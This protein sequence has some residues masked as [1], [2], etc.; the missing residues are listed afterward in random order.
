MENLFGVVLLQIGISIQ[1][2]SI[3]AKEFFSF[4]ERYFSLLDAL[5]YPYF[6]L[7]N[8][9]LR[10]VL[11]I[12]EHL[13]HGFAVYNLVDMI[14]PVFHGKVHGIGVAKQIVEVAENLLICTNEENT[15]IIRLVATQCVHWKHVAGASSAYEIGYLAIAVAGNVLQ[16]GFPCRAFVQPLYRHDGEKLVD[17][18]TVGKRLEEREVAKIFVC[19]QFV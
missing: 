17:S 16:S 12:L 10:V 6:E 7:P 2:A 4:L 14:A 11:H 15:K 5:G 18:P 9:F 3:V 1:S 13:F 19:K 8:K